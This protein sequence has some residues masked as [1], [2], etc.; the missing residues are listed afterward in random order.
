MTPLL[1]IL[2]SPSGAGKTTIAR[3]LIA[4]RDDVAYSISA[5]TRPP[6]PTE[7]DGVDYHFLSPEEFE[8]RVAA[9]AFLEWAEYSGHRYGTLV[10]EI[11]RIHGAGRHAIL[12]I[13]V[14]GAQQ[15]RQ[16]RND[17]VCIFV[18]PPSAEELIERLTR[19]GAEPANELAQRLARADVE[20]GM[21]ETYDHII[22]NDE[23]A[24]AVRAVSAILD[25]ADDAGARPDEVGDLIARLRGGLEAERNKLRA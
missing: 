11:E 25:G 13:E 2:S 22:V 5:T 24:E 19:R 9:G 18:V 10:A 21:A 14:Q 16:H 23:L 8:R 7:R 6:R 4:S 12:D 3:T 17:V 1:V 20:L 15:V